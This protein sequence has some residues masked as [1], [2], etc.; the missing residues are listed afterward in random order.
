MT[1]IES[2]IRPTHRSRGIIEAWFYDGR[3]LSECPDWVQAHCRGHLAPN[4]IGRYAV[5]DDEGYFWMWMTADL[6]N[7]RYERI[8]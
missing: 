4:R 3:A 8:Y 2:E 7:Q 6:L 1:I 5:R